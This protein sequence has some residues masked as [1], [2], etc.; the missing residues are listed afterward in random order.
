MTVISVE[1]ADEANPTELKTWFINNPTVVA[2]FILNDGRM[3][4]IFY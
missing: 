3:F 1:V 2:K 4:F